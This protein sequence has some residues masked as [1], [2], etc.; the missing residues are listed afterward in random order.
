MS[1]WTDNKRYYS[2]H[3]NDIWIDSH[4][5]IYKIT[6]DQKIFDYRT[7]GRLNYK[8]TLKNFYKEGYT[9][10]NIVYLGREIVF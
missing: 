4:Y 7:R 3:G 1:R 6:T 5:N 8:E 2:K 10:V 9:N